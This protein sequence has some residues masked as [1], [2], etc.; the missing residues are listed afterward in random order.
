LCSPPDQRGAVCG[1]ETDDIA[2]KT[3]TIY[4]DCQTYG[5]AAVA[6]FQ[7]SHAHCVMLPAPLPDVRHTLLFPSYI[8]H[9]HTPCHL[10]ATNPILPALP[11]VAR[12]AAQQWWWC[13]QASSAKACSLAQHSL[14]RNSMPPRLACTPQQAA[15]LPI[16]PR[17]SMS[18]SGQNNARHIHAHR[19]GKK[20]N[21]P[22][23]SKR[24]APP[25]ACPPRGCVT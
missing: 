14:G 3:N 11:P 22:R 10:S 18:T 2:R 12:H 23:S 6:T 24:G 16:P 4:N 15:M 1:H 17:S 19:R 13:Q 5:P 25:A 9:T 8:L 20:S 21:R 7:R